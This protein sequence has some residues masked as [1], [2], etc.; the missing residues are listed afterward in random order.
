MGA[1]TQGNQP[2]KVQLE[3]PG[4]EYERR[5]KRNRSMGAFR[6]IELKYLLSNE[7]RNKQ[8]NKQKKLQ[9][10][11]YQNIFTFT[12]HNFSRYTLLQEVD[13]SIKKQE[14]TIPNSFAGLH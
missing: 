10:S 11:K 14:L 7:Q 1:L 12:P 4:R 2:V 8:T 6:L 5:L 9:S 3:V 13:Q